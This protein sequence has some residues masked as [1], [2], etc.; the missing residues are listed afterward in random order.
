MS[1][2]TAQRQAL[3]AV[4]EDVALFYRR[5]LLGRYGVG[6]REYLIGRGFGDLLA[7]DCPWTVG[8]APPAWTAAYD[9]LACLGYTD[10]VLLASGVV[11]TSRRG[12]LIDT[13]RDR[14]TF[15]VRGLDRHLVGFVARRGPGSKDCVGPKYLNTRRS[16]IYDKSEALFGLGETPASPSA[17]L[18]SEGPFD[19]IALG[20]THSSGR[21]TVASVATCG[22]ALTLAH[23]VAITD[24]HPRKVVLAFDPDAAGARALKN[25]YARLSSIKEV[26]ALAA[27]AGIDPADRW[28]EG[29]AAVRAAV[30]IAIP[31]ADAIVD[32]HFR[33]WSPTQTGVEAELCL[34]REVLADVRGLRV[35]DIARQIGRLSQLLPFS[36]WEITEELVAGLLVQAADRPSRTTRGHQRT[37][38]L[39]R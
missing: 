12:T 25:A 7:E 20:M 9:H 30:K 19:A 6:P 13:F 4:N 17:V 37:N 35:S 8:Y 1:D 28:R 14:I 15:G 10:D 23:A 16:A 3:V 5:Q 26:R 38:R 36:H 22:S 11:S 2:E 39:G 18:V 29:P 32:E 21:R 34:L 27:P 33:T 31:A 24:L